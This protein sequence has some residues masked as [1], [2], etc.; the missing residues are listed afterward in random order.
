ME[1]IF[2]K[3][4][5]LSICNKLVQSLPKTELPKFFYATFSKLD[6]FFWSRFRKSFVFALK[7]HYLATIILV[8][9]AHGVPNKSK[10]SSNH[11]N[12]WLAENWG[13]VTIF[14]DTR[15]NR[16]LIFFTANHFPF[17]QI[18]IA[19]DKTCI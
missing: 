4:V 19:G 3:M 18:I 6:L 15:E 7:H 1:I 2:G 16:T 5:D 9:Q 13:R 10:M 8:L 14:W 11:K 17:V 12:L